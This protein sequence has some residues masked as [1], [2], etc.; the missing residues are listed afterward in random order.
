[1]LA[2]VLI[3]VMVNLNL[4]VFLHR[5]VAANQS[6]ME[7]LGVKNYFDLLLLSISYFFLHYIYLIA[8]ATSYFAH[9]YY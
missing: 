1:M 4:S 5:F 7:F 6:D 9:L 8:L 3:M 2:D